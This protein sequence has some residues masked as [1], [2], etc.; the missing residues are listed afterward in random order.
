M[1]AMHVLSAAEMQACDRATTERFG[2][3]SIL[4]MRAA[5]S[6]VATFAQQYSRMR[7]ASPC[8]AAAATT[9]ATA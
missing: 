8:S 4:L 7:G 1:K 6:A 9:A 5:S 3:P 2:V